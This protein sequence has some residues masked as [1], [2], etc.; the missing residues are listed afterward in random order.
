LLGRCHYPS[1]LILFWWDYTVEQIELGY[2]FNNN[3]N[4]SN[5]AVNVLYKLYKGGWHQG[6]LRGEKKN[7]RPYLKNN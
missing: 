4:D 2:K 7:L 1:P 3:R 6:W 5:L